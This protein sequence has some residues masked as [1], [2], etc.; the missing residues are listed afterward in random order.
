MFGPSLQRLA[1]QSIGI[2]HEFITLKTNSIKRSAEVWGNNLDVTYFVSNLPSAVLQYLVKKS[3]CFF[4]WAFAVSYKRIVNVPSNG[5]MSVTRSQWTAAAS[6]WRMRYESFV[7]A[8]LNLETTS[9]KCILWKREPVLLELLRDHSSVS[10]NVHRISASATQVSRCLAIV[11]ELH[12]FKNWSWAVEHQVSDFNL[13]PLVQQCCLI[14]PTPQPST[15]TN[16]SV[17]PLRFS[18]HV[19]WSNHSL[20]PC[21]NLS[22][23]TEFCFLQ[24]MASWQ[25]RF[26]LKKGDWKSIWSR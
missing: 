8:T 14:W 24:L 19:V 12:V 11:M 6:S 16:T 7:R 17:C 21:C 25:R 13:R 3:Y 10:L 26:I 20:V 5:L 1:N 4:T 22:Y 23:L 15:L 18:C 9:P 2:R